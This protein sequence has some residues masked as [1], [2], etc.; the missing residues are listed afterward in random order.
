MLALANATT[1]R[2]ARGGALGYIFLLRRH[3]PRGL[4]AWELGSHL[5]ILSTSMSTQQVDGQE[6]PGLR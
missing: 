3:V 2:P 6:K 5:S 1:R 4:A